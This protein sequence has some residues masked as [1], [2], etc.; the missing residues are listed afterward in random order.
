[1]KA[2]GTNTESVAS[3]AA[4]SLGVAG[5]VFGTW[6]TCACFVLSTG[7]ESVCP[8][9]GTKTISP[10]TAS[11]AAAPIEPHASRTRVRWEDGSSATLP[12]V[13]PL[14]QAE[15][16]VWLMETIAHVTAALIWHRS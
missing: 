1:M 6:K 15:V 11:S 4:F 2:L 16:Y 10:M 5:T 9:F 3:A 14:V 8:V 7:V 13:A 12:T